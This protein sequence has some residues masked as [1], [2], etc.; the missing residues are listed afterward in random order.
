MCSLTIG[1]CL[2]WTWCTVNAEKDNPIAHS[3]H[4]YQTQAL[5]DLLYFGIIVSAG[6]A[7]FV[8]SLL[9]LKSALVIGLVITTCGSIVI[10]YST[11]A[12]LWLYIG[13][14]MHGLGAGFVFVIVPNYASEIAEPKFRGKY[15]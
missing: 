4:T 12:L 6:P 13:R 11:G 7:A 15:N 5:N 9:G 3:K 14:I 2:E 8:S 1:L 10:I